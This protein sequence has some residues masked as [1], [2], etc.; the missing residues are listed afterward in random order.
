MAESGQEKTEAP[1]QRRRDEAARDGRVPRSQELTAAVLLLTSGVALNATG[2]AL[3]AAL[4]DILG[5]GLGV[6]GSTTLEGPA[7]VTLIQQLGWKALGA[8]GAFLATMV[9]ASIAIGAVQARGV[10]SMK[11]VLPDVNRLNPA[12]NV[13]RILGVQGVVELAKSLLKL[14]IVELGGVARARARVAG[15]HRVGPAAAARPARRRAHATDSASC[16]TRGW[17]TSRSPP[18]TTRGSSGSTSR[19]CA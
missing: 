9:G 3:A 10:V 1:T 8:L 2:P 14:A 18:P 12:K 17:P 6:A 5:T 15:D 4:R 11:P 19:G 7:A 16:A 13:G